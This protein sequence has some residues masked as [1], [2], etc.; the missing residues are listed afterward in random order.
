MES[1]RPPLR[2]RALSRDA[3][4]AQAPALA[5]A[6]P[7]AAPALSQLPPASRR[8][9]RLR[10]AR[11]GIVASALQSLRARDLTPVRSIR[12]AMALEA[13]ASSRPM[14]AGGRLGWPR[15]PME[16]RSATV[17]ATSAVGDT[18][19]LSRTRDQFL[20]RWMGSSDALSASGVHS[21][22]EFGR[23]LE[24]K[25]GTQG[26]LASEGEFI[27]AFLR[28]VVRTA[29]ASSVP[30]RSAQIFR[31]GVVVAAIMAG[32]EA[33]DAPGLSRLLTRAVLHL[34]RVPARPGFDP[35]E[36]ALLGIAT[37]LDGQG[38]PCGHLNALFDTVMSTG[39]EARLLLRFA[40]LVTV[41]GADRMQARA[42]QTLLAA[43]THAPALGAA[44]RRS[45][46][47][48]LTPLVARFQYGVRHL[49]H[50]ARDLSAPQLQRLVHALMD[51]A[52]ERAAAPGGRGRYDGAHRIRLQA[53][54]EEIVGVGHPRTPLELRST[55]HTLV[56]TGPFPDRQVILLAASYAQARGLPRDKAATQSLLDE[57]K[58]AIDALAGVDSRYQEGLAALGVLL[59]QSPVDLISSRRLTQDRRQMLMEVAF[60]L[61]G[62]LDAQAK[63][64]LLDCAAVPSGSPP[65]EDS[66]TTRPS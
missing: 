39:D 29:A 7:L 43:V 26:A 2:G 5:L 12:S 52:R 41:A 24:G 60:E 47:W 62:L 14:A 21:L 19:A 3:K 11:I 16:A 23:A 28:S 1:A 59:A 22:L 57:F 54:A 48:N 17:P 38:L 40:A 50:H 27:E 53:I 10:P 18:D 9:D 58:P 55:P 46:V 45:M 8:L 30:A 56:P 34:E 66:K 44:P 13:R 37:G 20:D 49:L 36:Q 15:A 4:Q 64:R 32:G 25:S 65:L 51:E 33:L 61:P 31:H 63:Q 42:R 6:E 35:F